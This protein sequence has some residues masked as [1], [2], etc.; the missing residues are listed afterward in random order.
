MNA[1]QSLSAQANNKI[2]GRD[3]NAKEIELQQ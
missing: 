2:E 1:R 3:L